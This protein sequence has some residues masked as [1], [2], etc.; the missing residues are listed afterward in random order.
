M[1]GRQHIACGTVALAA[2]FNATPCVRAT[3]NERYY[4]CYLRVYFNL[5]STL[6]VTDIYTSRDYEL[7]QK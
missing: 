1:A 4:T 2:K 3:K 5:L 7:W 6:Y